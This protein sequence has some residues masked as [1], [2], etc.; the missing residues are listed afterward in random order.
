MACRP[1]YRLIYI[2][3]AGWS[4]S[5]RYASE[6]P[7]AGSHL[8]RYSSTLT[9]TEINSSFYRSHRRETY[10]RWA[11]SVPAQFTFAVKAPKALT[12]LNGL[13]ANEAAL[14][15]F[16][17]EIG[18][19]GRKLRVV[20]VQ[21]PPSLRFERSDATVF[22]EQLRV[23]L[24]VQVV[25][26]PRHPTWSSREAEALLTHFSIARVAADPPRF[27]RGDAPAA[28]TAVSY[29]RM[30]GSPQIYH[31]AYGPQ[32][33]SALAQE[34]RRAAGASDE[35]WCIFD[36]TASGCALADALALLPLVRPRREMPQKQKVVS[37]REPLQR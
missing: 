21:M 29:F 11:Q 23:A 15:R 8:Q 14:K 32:R 5:S 16:A 18:G 36:N 1:Q 2:G 19:L 13:A 24:N 22:F 33:R 12:H 3:T 25:C 27:D 26:E 7:G 30:H 35:V 6:F 17:T 31:S 28:S 4:I 34:L 9:S 20:L 10:V 37:R